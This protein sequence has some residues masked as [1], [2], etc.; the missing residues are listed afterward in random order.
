MAYNKKVGEYYPSEV[1]KKLVGR[2]DLT[3]TQAI[4]LAVSAGYLYRPD[5][6]AKGY[7]LTTAGAALSGRE[8]HKQSD[9]SF[10]VVFPDSPGIRDVYL[11]RG[12]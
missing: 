1:A 2:H 7:R 9:D 4:N 10:D 3:P 8:S 12:A 6:P 11:R 5:S